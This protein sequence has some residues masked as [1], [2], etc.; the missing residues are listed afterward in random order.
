MT[1]PRWLG[2]EKELVEAYKKL[3]AEGLSSKEI[4]KRLGIHFYTLKNVELFA[5]GKI[6]KIFS[7]RFYKFKSVKEKPTKPAEELKTETEPKNEAKPKEELKVEEAEIETKEEKVKPE[8][9]EISEIYEKLPSEEAEEVEEIEELPEEEIELTKEEKGKV[10][11]EAFSDFLISII[12][13]RF[14]ALNIP[15]LTNEE[16]EMIRKY[17]NEFSAKRLQ[18]F[19]KY[20]DILNLGI[21]LSLPF[22]KRIQYFRMLKQKEAKLKSEETKIESEEEKAYKLYLEELKKLKSWCYEVLH[23]QKKQ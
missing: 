20:S 23:L 5:E 2:R 1:V 19:S 12:D 17:W 14:R 7:D 16:K 15:T 11:T 6:D 21:A 9:K 3:K 4:C 13:D 8:A 22:V 18:L 10:Y